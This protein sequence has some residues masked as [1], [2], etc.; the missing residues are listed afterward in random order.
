MMFAFPIP[1]R[2]ALSLALIMGAGSAAALISGVARAATAAPGAAAL[3]SAG[4]DVSADGVAN[5][6]GARSTA[7]EREPW[8]RVAGRLVFDAAPVTWTAFWIDPTEGLPVESFGK[9]FQ[10][11]KTFEVTDT[12]ALRRVHVS[13][14]SKYKL[15]VNGVPAGRGPARFDPQHQMYD[16]L[17]LSDLVKPGRNTIAAEII[18]WGPGE[19]SRGGPIFQ[20]SARAGFLLQCAAVKTDKTWKVRIAKG[21]AAPGWNSVFKGFGYYAGNWMEKTDA[22]LDPEAWEQPGFDDSTWANAREITRAESWGQGDTRAPWKLWPRSIAGLEERPPEAVRAI[23]SGLVGGART[24][25]PLSFETQPNAETPSLPYTVPG[26]GKIH[27]LIFDAGRLVTAYP[28]LDVEGGAGASIE[29]MYA[30]APSVNFKKARRDVLENRRVEGLNDH[31][32]T[33]AGRQV[34]EPFL[35]RTFWYVRV[36][37]KTDTPLTIHGFSQRWTSYDFPTRGSFEC[38]DPLY[39]R[40]WQVGWYTLR[41]CAHESYE[42][43]PYY[44]Q[45]QYA[46]DTRI[47]SLVTFLASGDTRLPAQAVRHLGASRLPEGLTYSR[48]PSHLLQVIPGFSLIWVM[49]VDD[50]HLYAGD[51]KLLREQAA[52]VYS[53]LRFFEGYENAAGLQANWP[54]WNYHDWMF[55][56]KGQP[57]GHAVGCTLSTLLYK[58]ALD[59]GARIFKALGDEGEARRFAALSAKVSAAINRA[60]WSEQ[61]GLY[62]DGAGLKSLSRHVNLMAVL[63][64]VADQTRAAK[65]AERVFSDKKLLDVSYYYAYYLHEVADKLGKPQRFIDDLARWKTMLDAGTSTWWETGGETRAD[66]RSDCH[67]WSASPTHH[68][69]KQ[70]LGVRPTAPGF[71][72]V[73]I[74]PYTA[75]LTWAKGTV[76]TPKGDI[77]V[78]WKRA[79]QFELQVT[80]PEGVEATIELPGGGTFKRGAGTHV[81]R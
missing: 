4:A 25:P 68:L 22:R 37:V 13:A 38:S 21:R 66:T 59:A 36:A 46:G 72:K 57:P 70:V 81:L 78:D 33:R 60:A 75:A 32:I 26:D 74:R 47:Q 76:P 20:M 2:V 67:A 8:T 29:I 39:N 55:K 49:M 12:A 10:V 61:E 45:L 27:Y 11:R 80:L 23:Q 14:D 34:Y 1:R 42:D 3:S 31:Y 79:P 65:I 40:I 54:Y 52:G 56:P 73:T 6:S 50:H 16:T 64:D 35:H 77:R 15:W 24:E 71:S 51:T 58:G 43:C 18:Y 5:A 62:V 28:R 19:P 9:V 17:D 48:Y 44:E 63:F 69:M 30:E 41:L 53:V 7:G